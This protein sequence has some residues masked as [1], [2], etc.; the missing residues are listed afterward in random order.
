MLEIKPRDIN[1]LK[2]YEGN[3][4]THSDRQVGKI[5]ASI[6][7]FGFNNPVLIDKNSIIIAGHGR[8]QAARKLGMKTVP[9]ICLDHLT[10]AEIKA[11]ILADN[12]LAELAGWDR[13]IL[14]I[15]LQHLTSLELDFDVEITGFGAGEI[16]FI[17][18]GAVEEKL[19]PA[20]EIIEP[21]KEKPPVT[22]SGDLWHLGNHR[23]ICGNSLDGASYAALM[24]DEKAQ[25]VF[26]DPPYNVPIDGHVC[27]NGAIKH[28]EFEMAAGE[29]SDEEFTAFLTTSM[30]LFRSY[31]DDG[32][33]AF[34][35]MDWRHM[36]EILHAGMRSSYEFKNLCVWVKDNGGMGSLYRSRHELVFVFKNGDAPHINNVELGKNG[37]YRTNVWE[38]PGVNTMRKDRLE[39]LA[40]HP[41]VKPILLV[42]DAIKD[43]SKRR[44]IILD[45]FGGSGTTLIA[46]EKTGRQARLIELDP[47]YCDVVVMRWEKL[48]G[49]KAFLEGEE[50]TFEEVRQQRNQ[51]EYEND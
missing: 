48:T 13:E 14:A 24:G 38:Y 9:T 26:T 12:K 42:A 2:P 23:L 39:E 31:S 49:E 35:C 40:M 3:A 1:N 17:I 51:E 43:C 47:H 28:A 7:Q 19:D 50:T 46:A 33:I 30:G 36:A 8:C 25:M 10:D 22:R 15:E 11:Y 44:G 18:G 5:A 6:K 41:T 4:R 20:D 34:C 27:G 21:E 32:A 45:P 29:M 37:R 16:D